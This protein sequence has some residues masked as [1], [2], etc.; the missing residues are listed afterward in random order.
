MLHIRISFAVFHLL[1]L[2]ALH[3][4]QNA[5]VI[6]LEQMRQP[7]RV[8]GLLANV[9]VCQM[10]LDLIVMNAKR[11]TGK[12]VQAKGVNLVIVIPLVL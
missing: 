7:V 4:M 1:S 2:I 12:L 8:T 5:P 9:R 3:L 11:I 6:Y 10:W